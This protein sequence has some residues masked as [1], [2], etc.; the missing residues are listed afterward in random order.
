MAAGQNNNCVWKGSYSE[1]STD[2]VTIEMAFGLIW[3]VAGAVPRN[4]PSASSQRRLFMGLM[5]RF[6][7]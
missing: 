1:Y 3:N 7:V 4:S 6:V 5:V 2:Q